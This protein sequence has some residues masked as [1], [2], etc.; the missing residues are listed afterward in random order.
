MADDSSINRQDASSSLKASG[1][2]LIACHDLLLLDLDGVVY[3]GKQPIGGAADALAAARQA[4]CGVV[5][6]TNN[7]ARPPQ[8]VAD[9]LSAM[10]VPAGPDEVMTSAVAAA[11]VLSTRYPAGSPILVV[12]GEGVRDAL[13][14]VDL[15]PVSEFD[16]APRA[17][18]QGFS[19]EVGWAA[20]AEAC[21]AL[22]AGVPWIATN[23]DSTL[24][25]E[26]GP[27][28]GNG[29]L[30]SV[31]TT[32]TGLRPEV[33][34]KPEPALF[35][36]ALEL[37]RGSAPLVVGDRLDTDIAGA[38]AAGLPSLLVLTGVSTPRDLL[39]AGP[40]ARPT[41]LGRDLG[42]IEVA[43]PPAD[44]LERLRQLCAAAW[45]GT[46]TPDQYEVAIESLDLN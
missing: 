30:V 6:V 15:R 25:S 43:H 28:P 2:P 34:G 29:S 42:A 26:R 13:E 27:L 23:I 38:N 40:E 7:A 45:S 44:G 19:P 11:R 17:I 20:L 36:A 18:L 5:F 41:Y 10:G 22:R 39:A 9:Q 12:G 32:A 8:Q 3:Q 37:G 24:P 35:T 4:S 16:E 33:I 46:L 14:S 21:V 1:R 31:L